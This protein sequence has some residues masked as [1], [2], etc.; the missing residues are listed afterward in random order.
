M[1]SLMLGLIKMLAERC[2]GQLAP[3]RDDGQALIE[4]ALIL[5]LIVTGAVATVEL[6]GPSVVSLL[7]EVAASFP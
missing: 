5:A 1:R 6:L 2:S 7:N 3:A 4:Y